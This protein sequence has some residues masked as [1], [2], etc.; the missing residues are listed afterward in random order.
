MKDTPRPLVELL[1]VMLD[2]F[3]QYFLT[4]LCWLGSD[5]ETYGIISLAE[6][7]A[8][9]EYLE[10]FASRYNRS[11]WWD[12]GDPAP[13]KAWLRRRIKAETKKLTSL[14]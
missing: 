6:Y 13:R 4:G 9:E 14:D 11:Y 10:R 12:E 2:K 1:T 8:I 7:Y 5:L 3:D